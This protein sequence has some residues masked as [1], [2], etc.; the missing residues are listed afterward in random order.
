MATLCPAA[1]GLCADLLGTCREWGWLQGP[2]PQGS[3]G[4]LWLPCLHAV[5][6]LLSSDCLLSLALFPACLGRDMQLKL[7]RSWQVCGL[8]DVLSARAPTSPCA[9]D[10]STPPAAC[11]HGLYL[12]QAGSCWMRGLLI[13][14]PSLPVGGG[15]TAGVTCPCCA[16]D[17]CAIGH[18]LPAWEGAAGDPV[19]AG[20]RGPAPDGAY[21][22]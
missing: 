3:R 19:A 17:L 2:G 10:S 20:G 15:C 14:S 11:P 22:Q 18:G 1:T 9:R 16:S 8:P 13:P 12:P 6:L 7:K 5:S 21:C 4:R